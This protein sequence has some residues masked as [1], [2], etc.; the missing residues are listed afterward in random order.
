METAWP[1]VHRGSLCVVWTTATAPTLDPAIIDTFYETALRPAL[2]RDAGRLHD[3]LV[4]AHRP[5]MPLN[6]YEYLNGMLGFREKLGTLALADPQ[7]AEEE[8]TRLHDRFMQG[9]LRNFQSHCN[10]LF[11]R[12][13]ATNPD[14]RDDHWHEH[15]CNALAADSAITV[16]AV[17][18]RFHDLT[19]MAKLYA[20]GPEEGRAAVTGAWVE[21]AKPAELERLT[22]EI[23]GLLAVETLDARARLLEAAAPVT[24]RPDEKIVVLYS[25][26]AGIRGLHAA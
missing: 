2:A 11:R 14:R 18:G 8:F 9:E 26:R 12:L 25:Q 20:L 10:A 15:R 5:Q 7:H 1:R 21:A 22:R 13:Q 16:L 4:A 3:V 23:M 24:V 19:H 17:S 6:Y